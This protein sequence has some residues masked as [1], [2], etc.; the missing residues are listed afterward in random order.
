MAGLFAEVERAKHVEVVEVSVTAL[1]KYVIDLRDDTLWDLDEEEEEIVQPADK[2]KKRESRSPLPEKDE[3]SSAKQGVNLWLDVCHCKTAIETWTTQLHKLCAHIDEL[4]TKYTEDKIP[5]RTE[6]MFEG[7][8]IKERLLDIIGDYD[9][10]VRKC[11]W[12]MDGTSLANDMV[13]LLSSAIFSR[14]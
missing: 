6:L 8:R 10:L 11:A 3:E 4:E 12:V 1:Y 9:E 2:K 5:D 7:R 13:N 14:N